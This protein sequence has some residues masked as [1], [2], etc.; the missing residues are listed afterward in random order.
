MLNSAQ[1]VNTGDVHAYVGTATFDK[2]QQ[3]KEELE[4]VIKSRMKPGERALPVLM[5]SPTVR[6]LLP[7][8]LCI[9]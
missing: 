1:A 6:T 8:C 5:S 2:S 9:P 3:Y 4:Q 7:L